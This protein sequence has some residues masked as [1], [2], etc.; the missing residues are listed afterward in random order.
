MHQLR[1]RGT[2]KLAVCRILSCRGLALNSLPVVIGSG[3]HPFPFRT[4]KLTLIPPMLLWGNLHGRVGRCRHY[5]RR[6]DV[7]DGI[8]PFFFR[9]FSFLHSLHGLPWSF[10]KDLCRSLAPVRSPGRVGRCRHYSR[11]PP[12]SEME[13]GLLLFL[14]S[15]QARCERLHRTLTALGG[16]GV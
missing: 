10:G 2:K 8:G 16:P 1:A 4:R 15:C 9:A 13:S 7:K 14:R 6:P 3:S 12:M 11:R 5:S